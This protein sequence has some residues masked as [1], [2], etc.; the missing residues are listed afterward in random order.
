MIVCVGDGP[1]RSRRGALSGGGTRSLSLMVRITH[2]SGRSRRCARD[3]RTILPCPGR[4]GG[5]AGLFLCGRGDPDRAPP[6]GAPAADLGSGRSCHT[7][8]RHR[9]LHQAPAAWRS[10]IRRGRRCQCS[11]A[12]RERRAA[13]RALGG[14]NGEVSPGAR[15]TRPRC[16]GP[17]PRRAGPC[18]SDR[19]GS[20]WSW[21]PRDDAVGQWRRDDAALAHHPGRRGRRHR[22]GPMAEH[23]GGAGASSACSPNSPRSPSFSRSPSGA[24]EGAVG[25]LAG[26]SCR[27]SHGE[28]ATDLGRCLAAMPAPAQNPPRARS[29]AWPERTGFPSSAGS[30][31]AWS[32][33]VEPRDPP[34]D[35]LRAGARRSARRGRRDPDGE[36]AAAGDRNDGPGGLSP[37]CPSPFSSPSIP[38][39]DFPEFLYATD[40]DP[41]PRGRPKANDPMSQMTKALVRLTELLRRALQ[42]RDAERGDVPRLGAPSPSERP[43]WSP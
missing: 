15:R 10:A 35:V 19:G 28:L 24:G 16:R 34:V 33:A 37:C 30:L 3:E 14:A 13:G 6:G 1:T 25:A 22:L 42:D 41:A 38:G 9:R 11:G 2:D 31:T 27:L 32:S 43:G 4:S 39:S 12:S 40:H 18:G 17:L 23:A 7:P 36:G 26:T 29:V 8:G 5:L 21:R 20:R